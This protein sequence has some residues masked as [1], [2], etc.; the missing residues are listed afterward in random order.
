VTKKVVNLFLSKNVHP[1]ENP[2]PYDTPMKVHNFVGEFTKNTGE[3]IM[4][5]E[6]GE[7]GIGD[8]NW[9][10]SSLFDEKIG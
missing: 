4:H 9:K 3:T 10:K 8:D 7:G 6:G 5:L 1:R 2:S